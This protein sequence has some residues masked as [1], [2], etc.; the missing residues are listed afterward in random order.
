MRDFFATI[1]ETESMELYEHIYVYKTMKNDE[2][3]LKRNIN[4][5]KNDNLLN[6]VVITST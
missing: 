1:G 4:K 5:Y 6:C 2:F 3:N